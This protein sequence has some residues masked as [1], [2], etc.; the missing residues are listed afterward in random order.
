MSFAT[1]REAIDA[2]MTFPGVYEAYPFDDANWTVMRHG[3]NHRVFAMIYEHLGGLWM[4]VKA[5]PLAVRLWQQIFPAVV[6]AYHMNKDHW[7]SIV[8]DGSM[9][10]EE[11]MRLIADSYHLTMPKQGTKKAPKGLEEAKD[12]D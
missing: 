7:V 5:E 12:Q 2:C 11:I 3:S 6:P 10:D 9:K 4:N 1:R 8:L